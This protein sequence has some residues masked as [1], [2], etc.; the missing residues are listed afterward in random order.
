MNSRRNFLKIAGVSITGSLLN[1][2]SAKAAKLNTNGK[3]LKVGIL[4]P[5]SAEHPH[6]PG[7]FLNGLRL[8]VD[9][10]N[11]LRKKKIELIT[12]S[13][14]FGTP[15]IVKEKVQKL[16]TENNVDLITGI[17]NSEVVSHVGNVFK[18]AEVPSIIANSGE[19]YL[20]NELKENPFLFF[21]S[22]NL[23]QAAWESGKYAVDKF[24]K[25]VAI[26]TSFYDSG[27]D[28]LFTFRQG[29]ED[30]GG[31][32]VATCS[33]GQSDTD[34]TAN[35]LKKLEELNPDSVY[36]FAHGTNADDLIRNIRYKGIKTPLITTAFSADEN[37]LVHLANAAD[38]LISISSWDRNSDNA[39]NK[40]FIEKYEKACNRST[41]IF[42][43]LGF[44]TGQI[45]YDSFARCKGDFSGNT[46]AEAIKSC[47]LQS[48][49]GDIKI[50]S[51]SGLVHNKLH[52]Q[53]C[54]VNSTGIPKNQVL[55]TIQPVS[56]FKESFAVLDNDY[57]SGWLNP[58]LFV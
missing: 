50:N 54:I 52:I 45:I 20:V 18:N 8:G 3:T 48:P 57:R 15:E 35:T 42:S 12:E 23:F 44:E 47:A 27:Y 5:Q 56:E 43:V 26:V 24:G 10:N 16:L 31:E 19:S 13:V 17:L 7:S 38:N 33:A 55:E 37:R 6:Y 32:I 1:S 46:I 21:N 30:A 34:F 41:D 39:I 49:R 2:V 25:R 9:Q 11:A 14:N 40:N 4:L 53:Q 58:Y 51:D 28:S 36:V 22:L 29:V